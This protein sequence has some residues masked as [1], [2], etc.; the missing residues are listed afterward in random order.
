MSTRNPQQVAQKVPGRTGSARP[1]LAIRGPALVGFLVL[2]AFFG[3][4]VGSA[5]FMPLDKGIVFSGAVIAESK[6]QPVQHKVGGIVGRVLVHEGQEVKAGDVLVSLDAA[7]IGEQIDAL[8][9]QADAAKRQLVLI[10]QETQAFTELMEKKLAPR[11]KVLA[12]ERQV[13][14]VEKETAGIVARIAVAEQELKLMEIRSPVAGRVLTLAVRGAGGVIQAGGTVAEIVPQEDRL[15]LEGKLTP[16]QIEHA[17]PGMGAKVWLRTLSFRNSVP[18]RA[19][20][21][22]ISPDTVEDKRSGAAYF[23]ARVELEATR[24]EIASRIALHPGMRAELLLLT[25]ERTL[26]DQ[27]LDPLVRNMN[28]AFRA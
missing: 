21:S 26:L 22:W 5:A 9:K 24:A 18:F 15:V 19:R 28:R 3:G 7:Q 8:R 4:G 23:V 10:K 1:R 17:H 16:M 13:A 27:L 11:S 20:L 14:E 12:L 2:A 6:V 25:G